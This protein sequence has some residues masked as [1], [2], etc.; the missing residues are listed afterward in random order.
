ML[1]SSPAGVFP[2]A[3][4]QLD[5]FGET[6]PPSRKPTALDLP[7]PLGLEPNP[8]HPPKLLI[9]ACA[10]NHPSFERHFYPEGL[11]KKD[12]LS[13]Y[14]RFF[15]AIEV[16]STFYR[17]PRRETVE[18]WAAR[19]PD[20]FRF[21]VKVPR[22]VTHEGKL[23]LENRDVRVEWELFRRAIEGFGEKLSTVLLQLPPR[24]SL[25]RFAELKRVLAEATGLPFVIEFRHPSWNI[26]EVRDALREAGVVRA[27]SDH[28]LD[29]SR[30]VTEQT[31]HL[32]DATGPFRFVRLLGDMT[33]KYNPDAPDG[34]NYRYGS[35][36]FDRREDLAKWKA[37]IARDLHAGVP[38]EVFINNHYGGNS[39]LTADKIRRMLLEKD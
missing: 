29:P 14:A 32:F 15:N 35:I 27:W 25:S 34:K 9:G 33:T 24:M 5:M 37:R 39:L 7:T 21:A 2:L 30:K 6:A 13:Y 31:S 16:D 11:A 22:S 4:E 8:S 23:D 36:L 18:N 10:W 38:V 28:Y 20:D 3:D 26:A 19:T 17:V 1:P 12:Q